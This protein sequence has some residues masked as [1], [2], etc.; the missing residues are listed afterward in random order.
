MIYEFAIKPWNQKSWPKKPTYSDV[1]YKN[2]QQAEDEARLLAI[3]HRADVRFN[4]KGH[5]KLHYYRVSEAMK[6]K[7][8]AHDQLKVST[9]KGV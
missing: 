4:V 8:I 1:Q 3:K 6:K 7:L 5:K 2:I 9:H